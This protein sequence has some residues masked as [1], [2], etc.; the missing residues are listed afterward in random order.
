[1]RLAATT[2]ICLFPPPQRP[3]FS[4][5]ASCNATQRST[6]WLPV[7]HSKFRYATRIILSFPPV[8]LEPRTASICGIRFPC[9][10]G[11]DSVCGRATEV[12]GELH[13][14][15]LHLK[16]LPPVMSS[17]TPVFFGYRL[18]TLMT[19]ATVE[20]SMADLGQTLRAGCPLVGGLS[21][22]GISERCLNSLARGL[23]GG[24]QAQGSRRW[25]MQARVTS[26]GAWTAACDPQERRQVFS[27][28]V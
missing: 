24:S 22:H 6:E 20:D 25:P 11:G 9:A 10:R 19:R 16:Q 4:S 3:T 13:P 7:K 1:M 21:F 12:V 15:V 27:A 26:S 28:R 5:T 14:A 18:Q 2:T 8:M 17:E 23:P